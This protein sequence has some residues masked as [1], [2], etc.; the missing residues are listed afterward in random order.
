MAT[1]RLRLIPL[2]ESD[3]DFFQV[4]HT[5]SYVRKFLWDNTIMPFDVFKQ[6]VHDVALDFKSMGLWKPCLNHSA[7]AAWD[8]MLSTMDFPTAPPHPSLLHTL[9]PHSA[10]V[11]ASLQTAFLGRCD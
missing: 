8:Y 1:E 4:I 6:I 2:K 3:I 7:L 9:L 5:K 11:N 10:P